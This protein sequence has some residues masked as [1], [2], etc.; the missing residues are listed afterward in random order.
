MIGTKEC[1]HYGCFKAI[2]KTDIAGKDMDG[3]TD[4]QVA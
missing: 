1:M 2:S 4:Q 3:T